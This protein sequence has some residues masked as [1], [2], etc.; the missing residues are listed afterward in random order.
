MK[1]LFLSI[2]AVAVLTANAQVKQLVCTEQF[3]ISTDETGTEIPTSYG[4]GTINYYD[5]S[6]RLYMDQNS[7][8]RNLYEYDFGGRV[9][10]KTAYNWSATSGWEISE[11]SSYTYEYDNEGN[12]TKQLSV[13]GNY[14]QYSGY[15]NGEYS[16]MENVDA[17]GNVFYTAEY[18]NEFD[19]SGR[20]IQKDQMS[21]P[22][23]EGNSYAFIRLTRT[24]NADGSMATENQNYLNPDGSEIE[25]NWYKSQYFY[26]ADGSLDRYRQLLNSRYGEVTYEFV[27]KYTTFD[28]AYVAKNVKAEAGANNTVKVSWDAVDGATAYNV[29][30]D[31]QVVLVEGTEHTTESLLDGAH[32]FY[33]QAVIDG[34][35]RNISAAAVATVKDTGKLPALDFNIVGVEQTE[36]GWGSVAYDVTVQF[37]LPETAS[38]ITGYKLYYG[39]G[40]WDKADISEPAIEN[41]K[42]TATVQ[43][44]QYAVSDYDYDTYEYVPR[45]EVPLCVVISYT[46]GDAVRSNSKSWNFADNEPIE[47][48]EPSPYDID[49]DGKLTVSDITALINI[50]LGGSAE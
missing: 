25:G 2:L 16:K 46:T 12:M 29:I 15:E 42:V 40:D 43:L 22:D 26:N 9:A 38:T 20:L 5:A 37:T 49:G 48:E 32:D 27:N 50:Y 4:A 41:G 3:S 1:K 34:E 14:T 33:V 13:A 44:G 45:S 11:S 18:K 47:E 19:A 10:K 8:T 36:T 7:Y 24:Y 6:G 30:Y 28:A 17:T 31:Q 23:G 39:E 35:G 21:Q